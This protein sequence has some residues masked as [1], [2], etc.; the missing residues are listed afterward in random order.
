MKYFKISI[1]LISSLFFVSYIHATENEDANLWLEL[2]EKYKVSYPSEGT[3]EIN[4]GFLEIENKFCRSLDFTLSE[5][6]KEFYKQVGNLGFP[7]YILS[8]VGGLTSNLAKGIEKGHEGGI[9]QEWLVF[10][11]LD[12]CEFFCINCKN[13]EVARFIIIPKVK[14]HDTDRTFSK[15][16]ERILLGD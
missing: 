12:H 4:K 11:E 3:E 5:N 10:G 9:P 2:K 7:V 1:C 15:W 13:G 6:L 8:P 14:Q 16:I